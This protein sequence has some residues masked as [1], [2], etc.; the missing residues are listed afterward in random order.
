MTFKLKI[1]YGG[2]FVNDFVLYYQGGKVHNIANQDPNKWSL[3][4]IHGIVQ[5][6]CNVKDKFR[7][8]WYRNSDDR[9]IS[10]YDDKDANEVYNHA[11]AMNTEVELFVDHSC[12]SVVASNPTPIPAPTPIPDTIPIPI[13]DPINIPATRVENVD[14]ATGGGGNSVEGGSEHDGFDTSYYGDDGSE[15]EAAGIHFDD[16][17]DERAV[18]LDDGFDVD[19][20]PP[21]PP[22]MVDVGCSRNIR[23]K[24]VAKRNTPKKVN[25]IETG[26][27]VVDDVEMEK[28]YESD[29]LNSSDPDAEEGNKGTSFPVSAINGQDMWPSPSVAV[30]EMLPPAYKR[31]PGRP[32]KLRVRAPHEDPSKRKTKTTYQCTRCGA[33]GHKC[34]TCK[35]VEVNP[36]AAKRKRKP[37]K[38]ANT[39]VPPASQASQA[40]TNVVPPASQPSQAETNIV[41][42]ASQASQ[43]ETNVVPPDTNAPL[44]EFDDEF[45]M[46][47]AE[48]AA[49]FE[50]TQPQPTILT[51][52]QNATSVVSTT[53]ASNCT[54]TSVVNN[55]PA[56]AHAPAKPSTKTN[57]TKKPA[58]KAIVASLSQP[59]ATKKVG[60]VANVS[61]SQPAAASVLNN[62]GASQNKVYKVVV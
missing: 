58:D 30:E 12:K 62:T 35:A 39:A 5:E 54:A 42:P 23:T 3:F 26:V 29:E 41:P 11:C 47:A 48:L 19:L 2:Q 9:Y 56:A 50:A 51:Q 60:K 24:T 31:G 43:A 13:P 34:T 61:S 45:E 16:S 32:K 59:A 53:A 36:D 40:E 10:I 21:P 15:D 28:T 52:P 8:W 44:D 7:I 37:K 38:N 14:D 6:D 25:V 57:K 33:E 1:H 18:G 20:E 46:L 49:A 22:P 4:E 27:D 55:R 17:E